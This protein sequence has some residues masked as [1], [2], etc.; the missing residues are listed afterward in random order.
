MIQRKKNK[1][2]YIIF[3]K[4]LEQNRKHFIHINLT[5]FIFYRPPSRNQVIGSTPAY[6]ENLRANPEKMMPLVPIFNSEDLN[7]P[8][9]L[10]WNYPRAVLDYEIFEKLMVPIIPNGAVKKLVCV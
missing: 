10:Y 8:C 5:L 3:F 9:F 6:L 2:P 4:Y 1:C 7:K